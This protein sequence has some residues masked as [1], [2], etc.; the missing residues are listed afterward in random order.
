MQV[1][2]QQTFPISAHELA[3]RTGMR[4][5]PEDI[6]MEE[7]EILAVRRLVKKLALMVVGEI[8]LGVVASKLTDKLFDSKEENK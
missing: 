7:L 3:L 6:T 1:K 4:N 2:P 5:V 8:V